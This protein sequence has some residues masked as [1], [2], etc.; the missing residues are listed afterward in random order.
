MKQICKLFFSLVLVVTF[1]N[2]ATISNS[3]DSASASLSK[4]VSE[5]LTSISGSVSSLSKSS[6]S[7]D[8]EE[9]RYESDLEAL[10]SIASKDE[11][12]ILNLEKDMERI[13]IRNG[14]VDW[15]EKTITYNAIGS[16]LK[17]AGYS[18]KEVNTIIDRSYSNQQEFKSAI[19]KG[20]GI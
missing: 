16:G 14:I 7:K 13:A 20:Y 8:E 1:G 15:R 6:K 3:A 18:L 12:Q 2:C 5:A 19:L 10:V 17:L 4:S 11:S 9:S